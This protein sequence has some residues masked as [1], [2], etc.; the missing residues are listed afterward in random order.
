MKILLWR[1]SENSSE[2]KNIIFP[3][4]YFTTLDDID[5]DYSGYIPDIDMSFY[6]VFFCKDENYT[7]LVLDIYQVVADMPNKNIIFPIL[8]QVYQNQM[9]NANRHVTRHQTNTIANS[10]IFEDKQY[11]DLFAHQVHNISWMT[12]IEMSPQ[13]QYIP[14]P[15]MKITN[16]VVID[17]ENFRLRYINEINQ[18]IKIPGGCILDDY[19]L[20]KTKCM[21]ELCERQRTKESIHPFDLNATL[22]ICLHDLCLK[23][24]EEILDVNPS[25]KIKILATPQDYGDFTD[26][27]YVILSF[28]YFNEFHKNSFQ[29][30]N[31]SV[32]QMKVHVRSICKPSYQ[33]TNFKWKRLI[34]DDIHEV[35]RLKQND[36]FLNRFHQIDAEFKWAITGQQIFHSDAFLNILKFIMSTNDIGHYIKDTEF[37]Y[38]VKN[39]FRK[40][41]RRNNLQITEHILQFNL[42][43]QNGYLKQSSRYDQQEY[44]LFPE[45]IT[46]TVQQVFNIFKEKDRV[47]KQ[48]KIEIKRQIEN[49][50]SMDTD[51]Y[52]Q[53]STEYHHL[54]LKEK[55]FTFL[56]NNLPIIE[57][58]ECGICY[59][60]IDIGN[61]SI[62]KCGHHGCYE[63]LI[64]TYHVTRSCPFCRK[65]MFPEDIFLIEEGKSISKHGPKIKQLLNDLVLPLKTVIYLDHHHVP[66]LVEIF[67][68]NN[69]NYKTLKGTM[70]SKYNTIK[71]FEKENFILILTNPLVNYGIKNIERILI[72]ENWYKDVEHKLKGIGN[73]LGHNKLVSIK[74]Y[75]ID[76]TFETG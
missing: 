66:K 46:H 44:C 51:Q 57:Q 76:D 43:E 62:L 17:I 12:G 59:S 48:Q 34:L 26:A 14:H 40:T 13:F 61:M 49:S 69:I 55:D 21:I 37:L 71:Q 24:C 41:T 70:K 29:E 30:Y 33:V 58:R 3:L 36:Y 54:S 9:S 7:F 15:Y 38:H 20:G 28:K 27:D 65:P 52:R 42:V 35:F 1:L 4:Q 63:C 25:A 39:N 23:W 16:N 72:L 11:N 18:Y 32:N 8:K 5:N 31:G 53:M 50:N 67:E 45:I 6:N 73:H 68:N 56:E 19:G 47:I 22:I 74:Q 2:E 10:H 64:K 60:H 75:L